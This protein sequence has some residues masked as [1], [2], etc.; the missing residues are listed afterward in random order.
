MCAKFLVIK[1][2]AEYTS[3]STLIQ[4][5][6]FLTLL[7]RFS[8]LSSKTLFRFIKIP[9]ESNWYNVFERINVQVAKLIGA[10]DL[11]WWGRGWIN[12]IA[13]LSKVS[14]YDYIK[15]SLFIKKLSN[16]EGWARKKRWL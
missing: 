4:L 15:I 14:Q 7:L 6:K 2:I 12:L 13:W 9:V 3:L 10:R 16:T 5:T 8:Q 1:P 11:K